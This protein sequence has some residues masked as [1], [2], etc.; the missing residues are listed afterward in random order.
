MEG[1]GGKV[2]NS[3][4]LEGANGGSDRLKSE[5]GGKFLKVCAEREGACQGARRQRPVSPLLS[6]LFI[7]F[8]L[9]FQ[10]F[11]SF[12]SLTL[13]SFLPLLF[14]FLSFP[15]CFPLSFSLLTVSLS[16]PFSLFS[17]PSFSLPFSFFRFFPFTLF[18][19]P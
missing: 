16:L 13:S 8:F 10:S 15:S 11:S 5:S 4:A 18:L 7:F 1:F 3:W 17:P 12:L 9:L 14:H 6:P 2:G 19:F